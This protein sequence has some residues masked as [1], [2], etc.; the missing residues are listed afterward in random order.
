MGSQEHDMLGDILISPEIVMLGL[1]ADT[2]MEAIDQLASLLYSKGIVKE[3]YIPAVKQREVDYCT[4]LAFESMGVAL[5]HTDT[6]HV[7][8]QAIAIGVLDRPV[9]FR[10]MGMPE[11]TVEVSMMFMLAITKPDAEL[12]F[13]SKMV[14]VFQQPGCLDRVKQARNAVEAA[15]TFRSFFNGIE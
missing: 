1:K 5:P 4:G 10:A 7:N 3:S 15:E 9:L 14:D 6:E 11:E 8:Q 12:E 2:D 13:L